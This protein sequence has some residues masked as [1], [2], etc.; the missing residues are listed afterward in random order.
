MRKSYRLLHERFGY[1]P[2]QVVYDFDGYTYGLV[3]DDI[4]WTG[5]EHIAVTINKSGEG[6]FFTVPK[7]SL[8]E[9]ELVY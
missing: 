9:I 6:P 5:K 4:R 2:N 8:E 1:H 7:E 3:S